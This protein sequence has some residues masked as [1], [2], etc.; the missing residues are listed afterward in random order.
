VG[1]SLWAFGAVLGPVALMTGFR[2]RGFNRLS[3]RLLFAVRWS[4]MN[5]A[6]GLEDR[7]WSIMDDAVGL[8]DRRF[9]GPSLLLLLLRRTMAAGAVADDSLPLVVCDRRCRGL[10]PFR[11]ALSLGALLRLVGA[12]AVVGVCSLL[13]CWCL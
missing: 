12:S 10:L 6:V 5:D 4:M 11:L 2:R 1:R 3:L 7:R 9:G 13:S 8:E